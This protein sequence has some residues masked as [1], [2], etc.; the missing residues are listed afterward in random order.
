MSKRMNLDEKISAKNLFYYHCAYE[1][2]RIIPDRQTAA[3]YLLDIEYLQSENEEDKKDIL[4]NCYGD[5]LYANLLENER[6]ADPEEDPECFGKRRTRY[7]PSKKRQEELEKIREDVEK[8]NAKI[9]DISVTE[10]VYNDI[11]A[12]KTRKDCV[13]DKYLLFIIYVLVKRVINRYGKKNDYIRIYK[14]K[15]SSKCTRATLDGWLEAQCSDKGLKRLEKKGYIKVEELKNYTKVWFTMK[16]EAEG[17]EFVCV[18]HKN[19]LISLF[20]KN[21]EKCVKQ[22]VYCKNDFLAHGNEKTCSPECS[23]RQGKMKK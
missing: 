11:M 16:V 17:K 6:V 4:W 23:K 19:P 20:K 10:N 14:N 5:I 9:N 7:V 12:I 13:N 2:E 8:E 1:I 15:R 18:K 21:K 3:N 22:C